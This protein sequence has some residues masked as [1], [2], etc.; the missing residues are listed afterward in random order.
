M[1][2]WRLNLILILI[3][4][5]G[6]GLLG[7]LFYIQI[8]QT[9]LYKAL[10]QGQQKS[11]DQILGERGE[12][13]LKDGLALASN[14]NWKLCFIS[15]PEIREQEM[16]AK[17]LSEILDL[18]ESF[19]LEK[20]EKKESLFEI[21][22]H[23]LPEDEIEKLSRAKLVGVYL[24]EEKIREYPQGNFASQILGFLG[25]DGIGQYGLEGYYD[26]VL[27]GKNETVEKEKGPSGFLALSL[28]RE[29]NKG[30]DIILTID[31]HIQYQAEK[32]LKK[33]V[34]DLKAEGGQILVIEPK[35][36][37]ILAL[38]HLPN[39]DP[40]RYFEEKDLE[41]FQNGAIQKI[42][43]PGS[44]FKPIT[45]AAA[46]NEGKI[47][48]KTSYRDQGFV[49]IEGSTIYNY[50]ERVWGER[51]MTEVLQWSINTG[52]VFAQSQ[53]PHYIFLDYL[54]KFGIFEKTGIDLQGEVFS[55]NKEFKKG[56]E[57]NFATASFGQGIEMTPIQLVRAYSAFANEGNMVKPYI[58][59]PISNN[60]SKGVAESVKTPVISPETASKITDML[61]SVVENGFGKAAKIP[62][63]FIAGKTG[64]SQ[65]PFSALGENKKGYS[66]K[67]WQTFLGFFPAY[68]P[69][70]LILVKLDNPQAK[71]AEYSAVPVFRDLARYIIDLRQIPPDYEL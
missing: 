58:V 2:N 60:I 35:S 39:F 26:E 9:E 31:Y 65:I 20:I 7:R 49:K 52:A 53:I 4:L 61:V 44:S 56:Y 16:V 24:K 19:V 13:F 66:N 30:S 8:V 29:E 25:G 22:K 41:V 3:F 33:A 28:K 64:T 46:L 14:R 42:F 54:K 12:I 45:M 62:G 51:T 40:N 15:P 36:G 23:K 38:A 34:L 59:D 1:K 50:D 37:K 43:E 10:A 68:S 17:T 32:L 69:Q 5:F 67:T 21:L 6:A 11:F 57:I 63:Y 55:E 47:T 18:K 27:R 70:F 71:T 48:P